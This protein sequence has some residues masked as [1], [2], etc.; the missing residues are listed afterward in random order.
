MPEH[1]RIV[2][3]AAAAEALTDPEFRA[4]AQQAAATV[5]AASREGT[6]LRARMRCSC[7]RKPGSIRRASWA[8]DSIQGDLRGRQSA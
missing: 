6:G 7:L 5:T 4:H 2:G 1:Y 3:T 8:A